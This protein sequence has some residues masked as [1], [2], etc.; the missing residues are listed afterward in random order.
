MQIVFLPQETIC[1]HC[2]ILF[3]WK[4]KKNI[5][6]V[7]KILPS[8]QSVYICVRVDNLLRKHACSNILKILPP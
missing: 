3:C 8:M 5:S 7:V 2:Q 4:N 6:N 1:M